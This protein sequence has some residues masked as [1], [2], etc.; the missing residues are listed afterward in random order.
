MPAHRSRF[1]PEYD[2]QSA[3]SLLVLV[4]HLDIASSTMAAKEPASTE[5]AKTL[6]NDIGEYLIQ[7]AQ[8]W[9]QLTDALVESR[10]IH[11]AVLDAHE[12]ARA[13]NHLSDLSTV[14]SMDVDLSK[15]SKIR[16]LT[17]QFSQD[18]HHVW[19]NGSGRG[20]SS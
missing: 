20:G 2:A 17:A 14:V 4:Q 16:D 6:V 15:L 7:A 3:E 18:V 19:R 11:Q 13:Q 5:Q 9:A 12:Q 8:A 10:Q 1:E